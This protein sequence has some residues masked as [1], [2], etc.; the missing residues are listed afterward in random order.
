MLKKITQKL[1]RAVQGV[2]LLISLTLVYFLGFGI[3]LFFALLFNRKLLR[4]C[5]KDSDTFWVEA[6]GYDPD[7]GDNLHQS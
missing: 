3:T 2:L 4:G 5:N 1:V 6:R 7:I